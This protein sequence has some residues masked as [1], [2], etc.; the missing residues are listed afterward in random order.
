MET[1]N[2]TPLQG[3]RKYCKDCTGGRLKEIRLCLNSECSLYAFRFGH[4]PNRKGIGRKDG[5]SIKK[6]TTQQKISLGKG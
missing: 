4:N 1:K 3:I 6:T 5:V 2:V